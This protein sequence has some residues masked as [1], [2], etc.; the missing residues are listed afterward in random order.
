MVGRDS[1]KFYLHLTL[2]RATNREVRLL[3]KGL[4]YDLLLDKI[5]VLIR[6]DPGGTSSQGGR[7]LLTIVNLFDNI[8]VCVRAHDKEACSGLLSRDLLVSHLVEVVVYHLSKI[9]ERVLLDLNRGVHIYLDSRGV[10]HTQVTDVIFTVLA[11]N[12]KLR[13]P[14]LFVVGNLVMVSLTLSNLELELR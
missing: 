8:V 7:I 14:E 13:F 11:D 5:F 1:L 9:N 10:H 12:H 6:A 3:I 4:E 2:H